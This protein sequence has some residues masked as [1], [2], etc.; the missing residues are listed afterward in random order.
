MAISANARARI[1]LLTGNG[2]FRDLVRQAANAAMS[3]RAGEA[4]GSLSA[5]NYNAVQNFVRAGLRN[6]D[7]WTDA[8][9]TWVATNGTFS[10]IQDFTE[11]EVFVACRDAINKLA[12]VRDAAS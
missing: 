5:E 1:A 7:I 2:A 9:A 12:G 8:F 3:L 11:S 10:N 4:Q 6:P